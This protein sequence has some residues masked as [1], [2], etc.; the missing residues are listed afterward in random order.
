[1]LLHRCGAQILLWRRPPS[2]IWGG[3]W[4]L[5]EVD[6]ESAIELWQQSFLSLAQ[7]PASLQ[8]DVIRHQ[9]SHY[10]L[11]ISLAVIELDELPSS[12]SD[13]D[14]YRWV[15]IGDL[16]RHGLPTPVRKILSLLQDA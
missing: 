7:A 16:S 4:S 3:L 6:E 2:G 12:I 10:S 13:A 14:N 5:P 11:H 15:A 8:R 1:M 9:F